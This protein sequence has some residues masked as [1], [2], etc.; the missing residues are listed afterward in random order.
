[1]LAMLL[2]SVCLARRRQWLGC[3]DG[4]KDGIAGLSGRAVL[5]ECGI[6]FSLARPSRYGYFRLHAEVA[7]VL[8]KCG[9]RRPAS[10]RRS[11]AGLQLV[12]LRCICGA[13]CIARLGLASQ[14]GLN[15]E[16]IEA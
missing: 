12:G 14:T 16:Q 10:S 11:S 15:E 5:C 4:S 3:E 9:E 1:M 7:I 6:K 13:R 8:W 2:L